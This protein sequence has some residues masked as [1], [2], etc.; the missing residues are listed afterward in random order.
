[1]VFQSALR[2]V[3][4][5][6]VRFASE[7]AAFRGQRL[8]ALPPAAPFLR[9]FRPPQLWRWSQCPLCCIRESSIA[10]SA[11]SRTDSAPHI[12]V[13]CG[14]AAVMLIRTMKG[15]VFGGFTPMEWES[16]TNW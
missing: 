1:M 16:H 3:E 5:D 8:A 4:G 6:L 13:C 2:R 11:D 7:L 14:R 12:P 15:I 10:G 9:S